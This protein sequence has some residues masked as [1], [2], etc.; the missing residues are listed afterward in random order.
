MDERKATPDRLIEATVELVG[1][2]GWDKVTTREICARAETNLA[3]IRYHFGS[4]DELLH[5]A[6]TR[7]ADQGLVEP[8]QAVLAIEDPVEFLI[9]F[10]RFSLAFS[11]DDP[12]VRFF[13]EVLMRRIR[14]AEVLEATVAGFDAFRALLEGRLTDA[15][16]AGDFR[17]D[18][19]IADVVIMLSALMD[20]LQMQRMID[21]GIEPDRIA[22]LLAT[23]LRN[24]EKKDK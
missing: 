13:F 10:T 9:E 11:P 7:T 2:K 8:V 12:E 15:V 14:D 16:Q 23:L 17:A 19:D 24:P 3:S 18:V 22:A 1:E 4:K 6:V 5:A 21:P 20:G